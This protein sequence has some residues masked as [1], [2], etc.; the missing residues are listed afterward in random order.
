MHKGQT[1]L[2]QTIERGF[3][4]ISPEEPARIESRWMGNKSPSRNW[5]DATRYGAYFLLTAVA[6]LGTV[7]LWNQGLRR[8]VASRTRD[9]SGALTSLQQSE[10]RIRALFELANDAIFILDG[11]RVVDCNER[12]Q[13]LCAPPRERIVGRSPAELSPACQIDGANS[14]APMSAHL[15]LIVV[16][17]GDEQDCQ[18]DFLL[19]HH[20][21]AFQGYLFGH[22]VPPAEFEASLGLPRVVSRDA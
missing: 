3:E 1:A 16:A 9:L 11:E 18:R 21:D 12:A 7:A 13:A 19:K 2:L 14:E 6:L 22:P 15:G 10:A 5:A 20:G 4:R 17:E 8:R